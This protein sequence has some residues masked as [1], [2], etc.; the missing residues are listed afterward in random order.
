MHQ[1]VRYHQMDSLIELL[2]ETYCKCHLLVP[3][4]IVDCIDDQEKFAL[5]IRAYLLGMLS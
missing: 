3:R 1:A 4:I 2:A 5:A